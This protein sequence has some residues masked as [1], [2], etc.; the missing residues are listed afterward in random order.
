[1]PEHN[2]FPLVLWKHVEH[3]A[4]TFMALGSHDNPFNTFLRKVEVL[5]NIMIVIAAYNWRPLHS[6]EMIHTEV[7]CNPQRP[8]EEFALVGIASRTKGINDLDKYLLEDVFSQAP[9]FDKDDDGSEDSVLV[10]FD[11]LFQGNG[12]AVNKKRNQLLVS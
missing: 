4:D 9:V 5:K 10:F 12:I 1:M 7:V 11:Q 6:P 8:W 2:Y 3:L